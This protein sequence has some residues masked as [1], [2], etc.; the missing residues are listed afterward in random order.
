MGRKN[1]R[2]P[3][4]LYLPPI[5]DEYRSMPRCSIFPSKTTFTT[6]YRAQVAVDEIAARSDRDKKPVRV[7]ECLIEEGGCGYFHI[8]GQE[9]YKDHH[10][11]SDSGVRDTDYFSDHY[12]SNNYSDSI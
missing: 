11:N 3:L 6:G 8:T 4:D 2:E 1:R 7:Y 9:E 12:W 5:K 10:G